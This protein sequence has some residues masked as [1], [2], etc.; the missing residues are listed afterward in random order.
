MKKTFST[1]F[2]IFLIFTTIAAP[3][4]ANTAKNIAL[5]FWN[6]ST[7]AMKAGNVQEMQNVTPATDFAHL[8]IFSHARGF[9]IVA[10]D[11]CARPILG[12]SDEG[13]FNADEMPAVIRDWLASFDEQIESA[14]NQHATAT[15]AIHSEWVCLLE[16]RLPATKG[17]S[18]VQP[19]VTAK[20]GQGSPYNALCPDGLRV[21][22]VAVAM[23]QI[24]HYWKHPVHGTGSHSY[25][26]GTHSLSADFENTTYNWSNMPDICSSSNNDVATL[27]FHCG[28]AV[29]TA[30]LANVSSAYVLNS[31]LH[32]YNAEKAMKTNFGF[33]PTEHGE[34]REDY[35]KATWISMLKADLDAGHPL[36]YNGYNSSNA[37]G[38][39]FV[40]DGYDN[41][42]Y[43]HFNWGLNGSYDGYF[44]IDAMTPSN[45]DFSY[46]QGAIFSLVPAGGVGIEEVATTASIFPN[47][48][49]GLVHVN[50]TGT[51]AQKVQVFDISGK[52]I[53]ERDANGSEFTVDLSNCDTGSYIMRVITDKGIE[54]C[55]VVRN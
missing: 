15:D 10:G 47:P 35:N 23:G 22:C 32:P 43:F 37:G 3:V 7:C 30:Y 16:G 54:T 14:V 9:V 13:G 21:G 17:T 36:I 25:S 41:N 38:H 11:D 55:K 19:L 12:Y 29:E 42:N 20:W 6:Q 51:A 31:I 5:T 45:Q 24:M 18:A 46:N 44:E 49:D 34:Y 4:D 27:L 8:Y 33:S 2:G 28:V 48:T 53:L 1:L 50:T 26:D 52:M 39:C 40:C